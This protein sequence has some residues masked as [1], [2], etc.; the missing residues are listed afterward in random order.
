M[1]PRASVRLLF[2]S[3]VALALSGAAIAQTLVHRISGIAWRDREP[4]GLRTPDEQA[5]PAPGL[6]VE[7]YDGPG[8]HLRAT[9]TTNSDGSYSFAVQAITFNRSYRIRMPTMGGYWRFSPRHAG[10]DPTIDSDV[11][12]SGPDLGW[13]DPFA[14]IVGQPSTGTDIGL[15]PF[16]V[17]IGDYLWFDGDA[18]GIQDPLEG[19]LQGLSVELWDS[20]RSVQFD[21]DMSDAEGKYQVRAPGWGRYRLRFAN[22]QGVS[23]APRHA[24]NAA[25]DSDVITN[26]PDL[27]WTG[28]IDIVPNLIS[29]F[30][31]DAGYTA[32]ADA[33]DVVADFGDEDPIAFPGFAA[34]WS[35]RVRSGIGRAVD[36][37]R[38]RAPVPAGVAGMSWSCNPSPGVSCPATG[39][40]DL[41]IT[42]A[43]SPWGELE[44]DFAG[45]VPPDAPSIMTATAEVIVAEP[46]W[47]AFPENSTDQLRL[48]SDRLFVDGFE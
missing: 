6:T 16:P 11:H 32:P 27:G 4:D 41:D 21:Q 31:I 9:T 38:V 36:S 45:Q 13:S 40:D 17:S 15:V 29:T 23:F 48:R 14:V 22:P 1:S 2:V 25:Q 42:V 43:L 8:G 33:V 3:I 5:L 35:L 18:D 24:G 10:S 19:G 34:T 28:I 47:D 46:Q 26:W 30:T 7:L 39:T 20:T 12:P 44:I 37:V